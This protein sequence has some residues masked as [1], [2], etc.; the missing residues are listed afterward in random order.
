[1]TSHAEEMSLLRRQVEE[2]TMA[3]SHPEVRQLLRTIAKGK[4]P[5]VTESGEIPQYST[6]SKNKEPD[7]DPYVGTN[8]SGK[9]LERLPIRRLFHV[10][11][12]QACKLLLLRQYLLPSH[13][14]FQTLPNSLS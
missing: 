7:V 8:I 4:A 10:Q 1:M 5:M 12:F 13:H 3:L 14:R 2:L 6:P 11:G 9:S